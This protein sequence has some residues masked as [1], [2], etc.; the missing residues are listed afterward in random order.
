MVVLS[1]LENI[2]DA[3]SRLIPTPYKDI[4]VEATQPQLS[5]PREESVSFLCRS[6][7][8]DSEAAGDVVQA[9]RQRIT[10]SD[11]KVQ[12]LTVLV[13]DAL[14]KNCDA[15]VH[16]AVASQ[17]G[18]L[19]DLQNIATRVPCVTEKERMAREAALAL[20]LNLSIWFTGHPDGRL[21]ILTTISDDV[22]HAIGPNA[23]ENVDPDT[24]TQI[25]LAANRRQQRRRPEAPGQARQPRQQQ[26]RRWR[27]EGPVVDAV[28]V[29]YPKE[30]ELAAMLDCCMTL[31]EYLNNAKVLPDGSI[32]ADDVIR[33]FREK[34]VEDHKLVT[35]LLSSDLKL[36]NRDVLRDVSDGQVALL[37][38]METD[39]LLSRNQ[40]SPPSRA[41][42]VAATEMY[43]PQV[44]TPTPPAAAMEQGT[45]IATAT[46]PTAPQVESAA[47]STALAM[48]PPEAVNAVEESKPSAVQETTKAVE[49]LFV[50]APAHA[51]F[52]D[53]PQAK[54][55]AEAPLPTLTA[56]EGNAAEAVVE[57]GRQPQRGQERTKDQPGQQ[58][59]AK[60]E[61]TS[62]S[63][64]GEDDFDAFLEERLLK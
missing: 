35:V 15:T 44:V 33:G 19:R 42:D 24:N 27:Q 47:V 34:I 7:N 31:A 30:E 5:M 12:F 22:R 1:L 6:A 17:K 9:V 53:P 40:T 11:A 16:L 8:S 38:R 45:G 10:E 20:I 55:D 28:G 3:A 46:N 63:T 39:V 61:K 49:D 60:E 13:L 51:N 54:T 4:V 58:E 41:A 52:A 14:V 56:S 50:A 48:A 2:K 57:E 62:Q 26:Q 43:R 23:F 29:N 59:K 25:T 64:G 32:E 18:L 36:D 21:Y 37:R